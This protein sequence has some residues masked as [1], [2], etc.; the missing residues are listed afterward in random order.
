MDVT[1]SSLWHVFQLS[2]PIW[3]VSGNRSRLRADSAILWR[4]SSEMTRTG[5][6]LASVLGPDRF[7]R[8]TPIWF[9][10]SLDSWECLIIKSF[11]PNTWGPQIVL[12]IHNEP[13]GRVR[14]TCHR[15][16]AGNVVIPTFV[17]WNYVANSN[18][19]FMP[20]FL[21]SKF[22]WWNCQKIIC[23]NGPPRFSAS[24][25]QAVLWAG[26][27]LLAEGRLLLLIVAFCS[28]LTLALHFGIALEPLGS[29]GLAPRHR[30]GKALN[31]QFQWILITVHL[32]FTPSR[33]F[34]TQ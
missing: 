13:G 32:S 8:I 22:R 29:L 11:N 21:I 12:P 28:S 23:D 7:P 26:T 9:C 17:V 24:V 4:S 31:K 33:S 19:H 3:H 15:S 1:E 16:E 25:F 6:F 20:H 27:R 18:D 2:Y 30:L 34:Y 10:T 14:G 5:K